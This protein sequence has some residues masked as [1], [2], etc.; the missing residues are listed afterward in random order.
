VCRS[1]A[2]L[3]CVD[4]TARDSRHL[5]QSRDD[6]AAVSCPKLH[7]GVGAVW[8]VGRVRWVL[9][10]LAGKQEE[11]QQGRVVRA[12]KWW[13]VKNVIGIVKAYA[14]RKSRAV[15]ANK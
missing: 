8:P 10:G 15:Q 12:S 6:G 5:E 13:A 4:G 3:I 14:S 7:K 2:D 11:M 1:R 9:R